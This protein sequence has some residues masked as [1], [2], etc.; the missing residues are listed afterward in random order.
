M[1]Y[2]NGYSTQE[3][4]NL[5]E[6]PAGTVRRRLHEARNHL[7]QYMEKTMADEIKR[8]APGAD[9]PRAVLDRIADVRV[10][11]WGT[12]ATGRLVLLTDEAGRSFS[13]LIGEREADA[14]AEAMG[15]KAPFPHR[16]LYDLMLAVAGW[17]ECS[18]AGIRIMELTG[19]V[20]KAAVDLTVRGKTATLDARPS[21]AINLAARSKAPMRVARTVT[22]QACRDFEHPRPVEEV[23][24]GLAGRPREDLSE[25]RRK[26]QADSA[27]VQAKID[28]ASFLARIN[29]HASYK[30]PMPMPPEQMAQRARENLSEARELLTA[31]LELAKHP[32]QRR[33][34]VLWLG[35]V[36]YLQADF[37][38]AAEALGRYDGPWQELPWSHAFHYSVAL[39]RA[40]R[41]EEALQRLTDAVAAIDRMYGAEISSPGRLVARATLTALARDSLGDLARQE[42]YPRVFGDIDP[43]CLVFHWASGPP[44]EFG[45]AFLL[46]DHPL[47]IGRGEDAD[48]R[49][50]DPRCS[51]RHARVFPTEPGW[52]VED[53][54]SAG[55]TWVG[56]RITGPTVLHSG[57]GVQ[58]GKEQLRSAVL[59]YLNMAENLEVGP[60][61]E[62]APVRP[63]AFF[64]DIAGQQPWFRPVPLAKTFLGGQTRAPEES[65]EVSREV[66]T[67][68][69][70]PAC[71]G[72]ASLWP[73]RLVRLAI[74]GRLIL[75][76]PNDHQVALACPWSCQG[77]SNFPNDCGS[78]LQAQP[79]GPGRAFCPQPV[80]LKTPLHTIWDS[81]RVMRSLM[82]GKELPRPMTEQLAARF[83]EA[84]GLTCR[85]IVLGPADEQGQRVARLRIAS[86]NRDGWFEADAI[87]AIGVAFALEPVP[88]VW[89]CEAQ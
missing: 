71:P 20:F 60:A 34:A 73:V 3:V 16:S 38:A 48:I 86:R 65:K 51:P 76:G 84:A 33:Q 7:R 83:L 13:M 50:D 1:F 49:V 52:S 82:S 31:A 30:S 5:L 2:I 44:F 55:G 24:A 89:V 25:C 9:L 11:A 69:R 21:D 26:V 41:D 70:P 40:G 35:S 12:D 61:K 58:I 46:K 68:E 66:Q 28:L 57:S 45:P 19:H 17:V 77:V 37:P 80:V 27:D 6:L 79:A 43:P 56:D 63:G 39:H 32:E 14:L 10:M 62:Q 72:C 4:A 78:L 18:L 85:E 47:V 67:G 88:A 54:G 36:L 87:D 15:Q 42:R 59:L 22:R 8:S 64:V 75:T 74:D 29:I 81:Y 53:L 23:I